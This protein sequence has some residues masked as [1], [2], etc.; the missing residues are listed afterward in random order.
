MGHSRERGR[1]PLLPEG[2]DYIFLASDDE[3]TE[4]DMYVL[5][6]D[7]QTSSST[8]PWGWGES[9]GWEVRKH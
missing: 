4:I 1:P 2:R 6:T 9:A 7:R 8:L 3:S 5:Q